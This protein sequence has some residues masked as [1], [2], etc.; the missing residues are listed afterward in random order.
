MLTP[1]RDERGV[2]LVL[3][4]LVMVATLL[5]VAIVIDHG[6]TRSDRRGGQLAVDTAAASAGQVLADS[7][8][9]VA[10]Q[11][12][13]DYLRVTL[14]TPAFTFTTG[15]C[16]TFASDCVDTTERFAIATS[17]GYTVRLEHPVFLTSAMM[18]KTSAIGA[19]ATAYSADADGTPCQL[20][21]V[22][23][24]TDGDSFFGG[25]AGQDGRTSSVHAVV[26]VKPNVTE[27]DVPA[28]IMLERVDCG[29]LV[30]QNTNQGIRVKASADGRP[31]RIHSDSFATGAC[32][33]NDK[34]YAVFGT[35]LPDGTPSIVVEPGTV[36]P[37]DPGLI[38]VAASNGKG[39][40][41]FPGGLNV[42]AMEGQDVIG[43]SLVDAKYNS[44]TS[45]AISTMHTTAYNAVRTASAPA[46]YTTL[47]CDDPRPVGVTQLWVQCNNY[48]GGSDLTGATDIIFSGDLYKGSFTAAR[49]VVVKGTMALGSGDVVTLPVVE[50]LYVGSNVSV[51]NGAS[52]A[53]HSASASSCAA[54]LVPTRFV[55]F[56]STGL[57]T[58]D[59]VSMCATTLYLAGNQTRSDANPHS[60]YSIQTS[61]ST[62]IHPTCAEFS[63]PLITGQNHAGTP[64]LD[65]AGNTKTVTWTAPNQYTTIPDGTP[66]GLEDLAFISESY[67]TFMLGNGTYTLAITGV[68]FA[69]NAV[70]EVR[71][72]TSAQPTD[73]QFIARKLKLYQGGLNMLPSVTNSVQVPSAPSIGLIR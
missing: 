37:F 31:G 18:D 19:T 60:S 16:A 46:G 40:G 44:S 21:G 32:G 2:V 23:V 15:S 7:D 43:R 13:L 63:C 14:D 6:Y 62:G 28:F 12:A 29:A 53:V 24:T 49:R 26:R 38:T 54:G 47:D 41:A 45:A 55:V 3:A 67:G 50:E 35:A 36:A 42:A 5:I 10:C 65:L 39:G 58:R 22:G 64:I 71:A 1:R 52:L 73:A 20:F 27:R 51:A 56:G 68:L 34:D 48:T 4:A 59:N 69:P 9:D 72:P 70:F 57:R 11:S 66:Q 33:G 61:T 8:G 25:I 17:G 30:D